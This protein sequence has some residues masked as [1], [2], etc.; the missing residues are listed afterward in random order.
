MLSFSQFL[1]EEREFRNYL[2]VGHRDHPYQL[3]LYH[4]G[5][6]SKSK[7]FPAGSRT[8]HSEYYIQDRGVRW[9]D[10]TWAGRYETDTG[11]I[12]IAKPWF[13]KNEEVPSVI[14]DK[15]FKAF[16]KISSIKE[17]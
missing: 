16:P 7:E 12:S 5:K 14:I 11:I 6:F 13:R 2:D 4:D 17:Y 15:L 9:G 3:W 10:N 1:K 8:G